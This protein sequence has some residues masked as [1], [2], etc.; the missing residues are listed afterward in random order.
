MR[1]ITL[2]QTLY[3]RYKDTISTCCYFYFMCSS[4]DHQTLHVNYTFLKDVNITQKINTVLKCFLL[5]FCFCFFAYKHDFLIR[6]TGYLV[7]SKT[8]T[9]PLILTY[10]VKS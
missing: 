1:N 9:V 6:K 5:F 4:S 7:L 2:I 8:M 3:S 10:M